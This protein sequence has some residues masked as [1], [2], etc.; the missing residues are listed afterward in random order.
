MTWLLLVGLLI[1]SPFQLDSETAEVQKWKAFLEGE[2]AAQTRDALMRSVH[3]VPRFKRIFRDTGVP[4]NLVW[5]ALIESSF[6]QKP[7]SPTMAQGMYQFKAETARAFGLRVDAR[8]DERN[9]P[10]K[11]ATVAAKYLAYLYEKFQDWDLV[12]AAYNLGEGDLRRTMEAREVNTWEAVQP[13]VREETQTFVGKIKAAA[14]IGNAFLDSKP[15]HRLDRQR[16]HIVR[17]GETLFSISRQY[18]V[19]LE[20]LRQANQIQD[21]LIK[22]DQIL[23]IPE[24]VQ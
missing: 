7:T 14:L 12:L 2:R 19:D 21:N 23:V 13:F 8:V 4:D 16:T 5:I 18:N 1:Q 17:R 9:D 22:I 10:N 11:A 6:R 15:D 20:T 3:Y 24:S